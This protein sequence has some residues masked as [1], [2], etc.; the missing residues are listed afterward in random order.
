MSRYEGETDA[1][2][3]TRT[4]NGNERAF[5]ALMERYHALA[6]SVVRGVLGASDEVD[7]VVQDVFVKVYRGLA[8]FRSDARFSTWLYRIA[9]NEAISATRR[10]RPGQTALEDV[11]LAAAD[12]ERPDKQYHAEEVSRHLDQ[13]LSQL[14]EKYRIVLELRYMG[15]K[16]YEEIS[17]ITEQPLGTVKTNIHRAKVELKR[18]M[19]ARTSDGEW[20]F[21]RPNEM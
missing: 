5:R 12:S 17:Q 20:R 11:V 14:D 9:R 7:D 13:Y 2:L 3:V 8:R 6:Y 18:I 10:M 15:E 16:S 19:M 4:L 1:E 21:G